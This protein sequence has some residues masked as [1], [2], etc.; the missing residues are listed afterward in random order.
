MMAP[1]ARTYALPGGIVALA[2][3]LAGSLTAAASGQGGSD[4]TLTG[5]VRDFKAVHPD[6]GDREPD[7]GYGHYAG[8]VSQ[9]LGPDGAPLQVHGVT[10]FDIFAGMLVPGVPYAARL[11]VLGSQITSGGVPIPVTLQAETDT[12]VF[13]PFGSYNDPGST[14]DVNDGYNPRHFI[15]S[16]DEV[17]NANTPISVKGTSWMPSFSTVKVGNETAYSTNGTDAR[18]KQVAMRITMPE[19]GYATSISAYIDGEEFRYA[20]YSDNAGQPGSLIVQSAHTDITAGS[21]QWRTKTIPDTWLAAGTYWLAFGL[22][23]NSSDRYRYQSGG[24][25]VRQMAYDPTDSAGFAATWVNAASWTRNISIY[26]EYTAATPTYSQHL[27]AR[28]GDNSPYVKVL[29]DGDS[30]PNIPAFQNQTNLAAYV[31]PFVNVATQKIEI[32]DNQAIY[33]FE[34]GTTNLSSPAA[35]FQDLVIMITLATD[36]VYFF[37]P[38]TEVEGLDPIGYKVATQWQDA[39]GRKIAPHLYNPS[40]DDVAGLAGELS[41]GGVTSPST[42]YQ[43]FRTM[44]GTNMSAPYEI[45][46]VKN[47]NVWEYKESNFFPIDGLL[48][49]DEGQGENWNFTYAVLADFTYNANVNQ[50]FEFTGGDGAWLFVNGK[51]LIDLGGVNSAQTQYGAVD[52]LGL[53]HGEFCRMSLFYANRGKD[54]KFELRTNVFLTPGPLP[55]SISGAFD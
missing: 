4:V 50:W 17:Y 52:R 21:F 46:M 5:L 42:F 19:N 3:L 41:S 38:G 29:K 1:R 47:G 32:Q 55:G 30:V 18:E 54:K 14:G 48:Y 24:S 33:L 36:P 15:F 11:S 35:D 22:D 53:T 43:W 37:S 26:L 51:L 49:G 7:H 27:T 23:N 45:V 8:N 9:I 39:D 2:F 20:I 28:S 34:L 13:E 44:F 16:L 31:Q 40:L 6:F 25:Q 10:D 12:E